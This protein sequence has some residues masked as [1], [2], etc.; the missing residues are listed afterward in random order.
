MIDTKVPSITLVYKLV[1][2]AIYEFKDREY[3]EAIAT[4]E[5]AK[6]TLEDIADV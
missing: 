3:E 2:T 4:L 5:M 1:N 6:R